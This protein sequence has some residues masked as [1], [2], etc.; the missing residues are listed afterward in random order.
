MITVAI[1]KTICEVLM[2]YSKVLR[3]ARIATSAIFFANGMVLAIWATNI[4]GMKQA[5]A[6]SDQELGFALSA[7]A[8][9]TMLTMYL[10]GA[11]VTR[12]GSRNTLLLG[13]LLVAFVVPMCALVNTVVSLSIAI[14]LLGV[15][16]SILDISMNTHGAIIEADRGRPMM[17][18]FHAVFSIG[19]L[20][21]ASTV[22]TLLSNKLGLLQCLSLAGVLMGGITLVAARFL[23]NLQ[24]KLKDNKSTAILKGFSWPN[25]ALICIAGLTFLSLFIE[26]TL[27]DWSSL[28]LIDVSHTSTNIAAFAFGAFSLAMAIGRL[29]GDFLIR[30]FGIN[31]L[32][33]VSGALGALGLIVAIIFPQ[34]TM[35]I[36][37]F[38]AVGLGLSNMTPLLYSQAS[39]AFPGTPGLGLAMNGTMGYIGFLLAPILIGFLSESVG[40]KIAMV[41]PT[42]AFLLLMSSHLRKTRIDRQVIELRRTQS[43][44]S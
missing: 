35:S 25:R 21:G 38:I 7:F 16:N 30:R 22:A 6:L 9:G 2:F 28:Y 23:G 11:L 42:V 8:A 4:P 36:V 1:R 39:R 43:L 29:A 5:L 3:R 17:S 40:L 14:F 24:P 32:L 37:G 41:V 15:A 20:A 19:G 18:S 33:T 26:R 12:L 31:W 13:G 44:C 27:I 34:P 10:A